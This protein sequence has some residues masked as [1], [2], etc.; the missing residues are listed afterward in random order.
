[1]SSIIDHISNN[2]SENS[3]VTVIGGANIDILGEA[4]E[5]LAEQSS[6]PGKVSKSTGGVGKNIAHNLGLLGINTAF[7]TA[8]GNDSGGLQIIEELKQVSVN[9]NHI[10]V[11][12]QISTGT[13]LS[14]LNE[15]NDLHAAIADMEV[16]NQITPKYLDGIDEFIKNNLLIVADTNLEIDTLAKICKLCS[17]YQIKLLIDPVSTTKASKI[18]DLLPAIDIVT[19]NI[20]ELEI[21]ADHYIH[22]E[23]DLI[24][25]ATKLN[26]IGIEL[27]ITTMGDKGVYVSHPDSSDIY[28]PKLTQLINT[29]GA[30]D[31]FD[32]GLIFGLLNQQSLSQSIHTALNASKLT[33]ACQDSVNRDISSLLGGIK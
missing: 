14:I 28:T 23:D 15:K 25:A 21:L 10:V 6:T 32:A 8:V 20:K 26:Y 33:I 12:S 17:E 22:T 30:G 5:N 13:Y 2:I 19:P 1:M 3:Q 7:V 29:T 11:S 18:L 27:V 31:A 16:L 9:T 4:W 24:T